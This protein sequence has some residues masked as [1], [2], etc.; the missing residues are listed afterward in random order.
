MTNRKEAKKSIWGQPKYGEQ[1]ALILRS[2]EDK[3]QRNY[4]TALKLKE[5]SEIFQSKPN[6]V[7]TVPT[8]KDFLLVSYLHKLDHKESLELHEAVFETFLELDQK[9]A[10]TI[11]YLEDNIQLIAEKSGAEL[12]SMKEDVADVQEKAVA[13][14]N[15]I[16]NQRKQEQENEEKWKEAER[17]KG[18]VA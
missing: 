2:F 7:P 6:K 11:Q 13:V 17:T 9:L 3:I 1:N 4:N 15:L 14:L 5:Q 8:M 10:K 16:K 12:K 18:Y